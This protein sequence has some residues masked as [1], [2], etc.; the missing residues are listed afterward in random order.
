[1]AQQYGEEGEHHYEVVKYC[2]Y[3]LQTLDIGARIVL[4]EDMGEIGTEGTTFDPTKL[5][6]HLLER[7]EMKTELRLL[8]KMKK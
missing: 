8:K 6:D 1:M 3:R 4:G 2:F 7:N 5:R